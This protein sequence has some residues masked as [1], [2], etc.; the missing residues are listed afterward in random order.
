MNWNVVL[1]Y[2]HSVLDRFQIEPNIQRGLL[3]RIRHRF[4]T[5]SVFWQIHKS[6]YSP[7]SYLPSETYFC[8]FWIVLSN[9]VD[10]F[11]CWPTTRS[12]A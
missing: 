2:G 4:G 9:Q 12:D 11:E 8:H 1:S 6:N 3:A 5:Q 10:T 7:T